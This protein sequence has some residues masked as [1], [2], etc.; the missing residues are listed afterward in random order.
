MRLA[1][2]LILITLFLVTYR[3]FYYTEGR[4]NTAWLSVQLLCILALA[5]Y[6]DP[7]YVFMGFFPANFIGWYS[8][9]RKFRLFIG[10]LIAVT[11]VPVALHINNVSLSDIF[12]FTPF[13]AIMWAV[14]L[15][16]RSMR[17]RREMKVE[18]ELA[19]EQISE[20][21]KREERMRIA[22]DLHDT[23]GHTLSLISLKSQL[24]EKLAAADPERARM[25]AKEIT[26]ASRAALS[27]VRNLVSDMRAV[28]VSEELAEAGMM[29]ES[30]GIALYIEGDTS[31]EELS[32]LKQ[33]MISMCLKEAVTNIVR[34]SGAQ[35]CRVQ[36][37]KSE[38]AVSIT[39]RD[40]G[41]S[42]SEASE[43]GNGLKGMAERLSF[44]EGTMELMN[45]DGK[46][47]LTLSVPVLASDKKEAKR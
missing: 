10:V 34:H 28:R 11:A 39:V 5:L 36:I 15:F 23:L 26:A 41:G 22:R 9:E 44:V 32:D 13:M 31:L 1:V 38:G 27:Q 42:W 16:T 14:P 6:L 47:L 7:N 29:L 12:N 43:P 30:A 33:N 19:R 3:Q 24:V 37:E 40:N 25:E 8:N 20:M 35:E 17:R 45:C 18:L 21:V 2:G 4:S 46:T